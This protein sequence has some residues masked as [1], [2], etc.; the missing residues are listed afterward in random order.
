MVCN[1][2]GNKLVVGYE[3][4][5]LMNGLGFSYSIRSGY[6]NNINKTDANIETSRKY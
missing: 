4:T 1:R 6:G 3:K 5:G 2:I